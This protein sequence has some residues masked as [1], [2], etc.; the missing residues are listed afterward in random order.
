MSTSRSVLEPVIKGEL[1][2]A[3]L[4]A[5]KAPRITQRETITFVKLKHHP[6]SSALQQTGSPPTVTGLADRKQTSHHR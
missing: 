5:P 1:V 4:G 2:K 3:A 6:F